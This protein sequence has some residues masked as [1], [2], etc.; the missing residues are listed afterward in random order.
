[1]AAAP[2]PFNLYIRGLGVAMYNTYKDHLYE[3]LR[4]KSLG[5]PD[6]SQFVDKRWSG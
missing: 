6:G 1:M 2:P 3:Y 4:F 5:A